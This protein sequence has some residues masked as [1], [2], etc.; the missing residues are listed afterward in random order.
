MSRIV[1][2]VVINACTSKNFG[3]QKCE[4]NIN[5]SSVDESTLDLTLE[6]PTYIWSYTLSKMPTSYKEQE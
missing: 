3:S 1:F 2:E 5:K 4:I 6:L